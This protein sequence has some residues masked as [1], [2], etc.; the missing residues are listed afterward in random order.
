[1]WHAWL[2]Y[3]H[4]TDHP[5]PIYSDTRSV[6]MVPEPALARVRAAM[7]GLSKEAADAFILMTVTRCRVFADRLLPAHER[8]VRQLVILGAG[9]DVTGFGL[10]AWANE[11]RTF[12]VDTPETQT[13]KRQQIAAT[14]WDVPPNLIFAPCDFERQGLLD[15]L[16]TA[17]F[18]ARRPAMLS[19]FGVL[20]YLSA[21]ATKRTLAELATLAPGSELTFS[22][23]SPDDQADPV[24][25][26]LMSKST[27]VVDA[28]GESFVGYYRV[29]EMERLVRAAGFVD[30]QHY[31]IEELNARYFPGR[32]D[33]LRLRPIEQLLTALC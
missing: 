16:A 7:D 25:H 6:Q 20:L 33:V 4:A 14:G 1:M 27:R 18:D 9:L 26:E 17:G 3:T 15:A 19:L 29:S 5:S 13:W 2:R 10:P 23:C 11:W 21:D 22:Y 8:G 12:E 31:P 32:P 28:T 30:A 24:V